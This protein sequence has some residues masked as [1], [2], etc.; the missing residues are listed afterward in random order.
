MIDLGFLEQDLKKNDFIY[1]SGTRLIDL[2]KLDEQEIAH[3]KS[4]WFNLEKDNYMADNGTYR[5]RRYSQFNIDLENNELEL[6]P[7]AAYEQPTYINPLNGGI[8]RYY[9]PLEDAFIKNS[10]INNLLIELANLLGRIDHIKY[11]NIKLH[12]YRITCSSDFEGYPTPE[13]LHRDG[14]N[15][16]TTLLID[17]FNI[18]GGETTITDNQKFP[19]YKRQLLDSFDMLLA[20]D[21]KTMHE[22]S[23]IKTLHPQQAAW[24][25]V[26]VIAFS[27]L[28]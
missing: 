24:R 27:H 22:V 15:Y 6:L 3:L 23:P 21:T 9:L 7:H 18:I 1:I 16:I 17:R 5:F 13:G 26:L 14:V 28:Q 10:F 20:N 11:W 4:F 12:P 19:I 2:F 25:D 8:L